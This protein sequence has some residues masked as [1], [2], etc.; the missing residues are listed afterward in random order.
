[1]LSSELNKG[2]LLIAQPTILNDNS[3]NRSIVLLTEH[4]DGNSVGFI[5]NRPLEYTVNDLLPEINCDFQI[6]EGGPV[7]QE[8][9][10]F[11]HKIPHLIPDSM[12]ISD[13]ICWGGNFEALKDLLNNG[14]LQENEIRFFL[15]YSGWGKDQLKNEVRTDSWFVSNEPIYGILS[16][17]IGS[18]WREEILNKGGT[19]KL[20]VN[21]PKD[22]SLN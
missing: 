18:L 11:V 20:W 1:M 3:F 4:T 13:G 9:L 12:E 14:L 21:A 17:D 19:Y 10:Y 2:S 6:Y 8:N 22:I 7:E 16:A 5:I 15:G